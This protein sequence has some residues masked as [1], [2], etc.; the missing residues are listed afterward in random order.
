MD[1]AEIVCIAQD[2]IMQSFLHDSV[3]NVQSW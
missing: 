3:S 2:D 1:P